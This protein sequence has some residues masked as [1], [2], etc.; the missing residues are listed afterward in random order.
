MAK[1]KL[2][3]WGYIKLKSFCV[4]KET[5]KRVKSNLWKW[6]KYVEVIYLD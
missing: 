4:S 6:R 1:A 3:K 5:M 2:D